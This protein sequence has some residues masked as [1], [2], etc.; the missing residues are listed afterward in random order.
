M[1]RPIR[2]GVM[3]LLLLLVAEYLVLPQLAGARRSAH[4]LTRVNGLYLGAGVLLELSALV[5]YAELTRAVLLDGHRLSLWTLF[6]IDL[7]TLAVSH[8]VPGGNAAGTS[9]GYRLLTEHGVSGADAG[10][11]LAT[12]GMGS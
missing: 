8:M 10:F 2:R 1:I 7:S 12:Q 4:L 3:V 11:G 6:R 9:L 5:A